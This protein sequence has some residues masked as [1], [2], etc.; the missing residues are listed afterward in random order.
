MLYDGQP[1]SSG[2]SFG[3][4]RK[5]KASYVTNRI[6]IQATETHRNVMEAI[7]MIYGTFLHHHIFNLSIHPKRVVPRSP[8]RWPRSGKGGGDLTASTYEDRVYNR[9]FGRP[10]NFCEGKLHIQNF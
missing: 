7:S 10:G 2:A 4:R 3:S 9:L 1:D 8:P 6:P 5:G